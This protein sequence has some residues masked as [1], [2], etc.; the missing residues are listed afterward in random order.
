MVGI[1]FKNVIYVLKL[2][3]LEGFF[4][5]FFIN[6]VMFEIIKYKDSYFNIGKNF[7]IVYI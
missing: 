5:V 6:F 3:V 4:F 2:L 1:I 7:L